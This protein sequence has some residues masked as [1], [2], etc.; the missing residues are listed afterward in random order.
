MGAVMAALDPDSRAALTPTANWIVP[1]ELATDVVVIGSN[2]GMALWLSHKIAAALGVRGLAAT[3][4]IGAF[5][6]L[7]FAVATSALG[8][9][10]DP[11]PA[12]AALSGAGAAVFYRL[13]AGRRPG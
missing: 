6:N 3:A 7:A 13:L 10:D 8:F 1:A 2:L 5:L 11:A 4:L 12:V 9:G